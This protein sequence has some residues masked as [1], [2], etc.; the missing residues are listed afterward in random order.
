MNKILIILSLLIAA[1]S[2]NESHIGVAKG[3]KPRQHDPATTAVVTMR[4]NNNAKWRTDDATRK[5]VVAMVR[6]VNDSDNT[7]TSRKQQLLQQLQATINTL[8]QQ[9]TM[10]GPDHDAL[11][12]WVEQ[13]MHDLKSVKEE[14]DDGY[15]KSYVALKRDVENF[16]VYFE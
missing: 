10:K 8:L 4:L 3:D 6:A 9:C 13:V 1:C 16:Y 14:T 11:H 2:N 7:G 15:Q 12:L 5:N